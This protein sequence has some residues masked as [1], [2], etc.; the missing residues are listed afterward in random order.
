MFWYCIPDAELRS[1]ENAVY[2]TQTQEKVGTNV[3]PPVNEEHKQNKHERQLFASN[4]DNNEFGITRESVFGNCQ[5]IT[6]GSSQNNSPVATQ[7][8]THD[9]A[10]GKNKNVGFT[11]GSTPTAFGVTP[12]SLNGQKESAGFNTNQ[13]NKTAVFS[14][15][16]QNAPTFNS[17]GLFANFTKNNEQNTDMTAGFGGKTSRNS[18][19][20]FANSTTNASTFSQPSQFYQAPTAPN[21]G[22]NWGFGMYPPPTYPLAVPFY[23]GSYPC[24]GPGIW[25]PT[26]AYPPQG[27]NLQGSGFP[28]APINTSTLSGNCYQNLQTNELGAQCWPPQ[29]SFNG[30]ASHSPIRSGIF[31]TAGTLQEKNISAKPSTFSM[32]T[33]SDSDENS[34]IFSHPMGHVFGSEKKQK[35]TEKLDSTPTSGIWVKPFM[36]N[37]SSFENT[38]AKEDGPS[39]RMFSG[40][41][42]E[43]FLFGGP[44][45]PVNQR[46]KES[47]KIK[48]ASFGSGVIAS[49]Q[50]PP[51][52]QG[53]LF[54]TP[55]I[56]NNVSHG[57]ISN[58][59]HGERENTDTMLS[60]PS[61][62]NNPQSNSGTFRLGNSSCSENSS[63]RRYPEEKNKESF[64][65]DSS[66][67]G[68]SKSTSLFGVLGSASQTCKPGFL[69]V[70]SN[71][72]ASVSVSLSNTPPVSASSNR[73]YVDEQTDN[74]QTPENKLFCD[75]EFFNIPTECQ[76]RN[77]EKNPNQISQSTIAT[78]NDIAE[79][80]PARQQ[81]SFGYNSSRFSFGTNTPA[82]GGNQF[83]N[84]EKSTHQ[85]ASTSATGN[86]LADTSPA[87]QQMAFGSNSSGFSFGTNVPVQGGS[88]SRNNEKSTNQN[89]STSAAGND[90]ADTSPARQHMSFG[91]N[92]SGFSFGTHAPVQGGNQFI[93]NHE[94]GCGLAT[95]HTILNHSHSSP[96]S[97]GF[98]TITSDS[99]ESSASV[100]FGV[101]QNHNAEEM[102]SESTDFETSPN[103]ALLS[104][105]VKSFK[106]KENSP[107]A[108][109]IH[110]DC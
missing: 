98:G 97:T 15:S 38:K 85:N 110:K 43:G 106:A 25:P 30:Q 81:M 17:T 108:S 19:F 88:Q 94:T 65:V 12:F 64:F 49:D 52:T 93:Q 63:I 28:H 2:K 82:Q 53:S 13:N 5:Q 105:P 99:F 60:N 66:I 104:S 91:S 11:F 3:K 16:K 35:Q 24:F 68:E 92:S 26:A 37:V 101:D 45:F 7:N 80:S 9:N 46:I 84:N 102:N 4:F 95:E 69:D 32:K 62:A 39:G 1:E 48:C 40:S 50:S 36:G 89:A 107:L 103:H 70:Q 72:S 78:G 33:G 27:F 51:K 59:E 10:F 42:S 21:F 34:T 41:P 8:I 31:G 29:P 61:T 109:K 76:F 20:N 55:N 96:L 57:E 74:K 73:Q 22:N 14:N 90:L 77:N 83:T 100:R 18:S 79:T 44:P 47:D 75:E 87:R 86:D 56:N 54:E 6:R 23:G 71:N 67:T 58:S